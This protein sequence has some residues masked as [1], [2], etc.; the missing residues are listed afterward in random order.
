MK[1][2]KKKEKSSMSTTFFSRITINPKLQ[3]IISCY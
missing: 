3:V 1:N 2:K